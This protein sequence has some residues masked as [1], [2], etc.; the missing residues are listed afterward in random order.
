M[1]LIAV[2][3]LGNF[4]TSIRSHLPGIGGI[5]KQESFGGLE[6]DVDHDGLFNSEESYWGTDFQ[7]PDTDGD[8]FKDGEEVASGHNPVVAGPNDSLQDINITERAADLIV[9]GIYSGDLSAETPTQE[10]DL[11]TLSSA[12]LFDF[13]NNQ[14]DVPQGVVLE[15]GNTHD[16][17]TAYLSDLQRILS[18]Y[19]NDPAQKHLNPDQALFEQRNFFV[20][21]AQKSKKMRSDLAGLRVPADWKVIHLKTLDIMQRFEAN[22]RSIALGNVDPIKGILALGEIQNIQTEVRKT[23]GEVQ[24]LVIKNNLKPTGAMF[25]ILTLLYQ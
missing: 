3:S 12:V 21:Q 6:E 20:E 5:T 18:G 2:I 22:Y 19:L 14:P 9:G 24:D 1:A 23:L 25:D 8:G 4:F 10:Q 16:D 17:Q 13:Y 11:Q 7:N 15:R